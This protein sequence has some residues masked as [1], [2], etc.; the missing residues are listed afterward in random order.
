MQRPAP[1]FSRIFGEGGGGDSANPNS[2]FGLELNEKLFDVLLTYTADDAMRTVKANTGEGFESWRQLKIRYNPSGGWTY[3]ER[4]LQVMS[5]QACRSIAD[6]PAAIDRMER[7]LCHY[8]AMSG[9]HYP[10]ELKILLLIQ[11]FPERDA[12]HLRMKFGSVNYQQYRDEVLAF[13]NEERVAGNHRGGKAMDVDGLTDTGAK[14][15]TDEEWEEYA[16][17]IP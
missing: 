16:A 14:T 7:D 5:R 13:S 1:R 8:D 9:H 17:Q 11:L 6:L 15:Y 2:D 4:S 3:L 10:E 12:R